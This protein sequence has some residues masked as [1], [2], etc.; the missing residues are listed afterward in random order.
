[1]YRT[2]LSGVSSDALQKSFGSKNKNLLGVLEQRAESITVN[3]EQVENIKKV[4]RGIINGDILPRSRYSD[5]EKKRK[6]TLTGLA[7]F[8]PF[9]AP[10]DT[11]FIA[12]EYWHFSTAVSAL[13]QSAS[14]VTVP[15]EEE[16]N[17]LFLADIEKNT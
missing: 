16:H 4:L 17:F 9:L 1:M 2:I 14:E 3:E 6:K 7:R 5:E 13:V 11:R 12:C 15:K 10:K 8:L